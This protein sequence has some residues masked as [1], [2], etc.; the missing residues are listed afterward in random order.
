[1]AGEDDLK[2]SA[3]SY[4]LLYNRLDDIYLYRIILIHDLMTAL[5]SF[6][7]RTGYIDVAISA[8]SDK[9]A[10]PTLFPNLD[11][12]AHIINS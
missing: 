6:S 1:M 9:K 11:P 4:Y 5:L 10:V 2:W 3:I 8:C 12:F 7:T